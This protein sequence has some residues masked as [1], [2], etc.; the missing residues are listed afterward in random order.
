MSNAPQR[1]QSTAADLQLCIGG[2]SSKGLK[3]EN[4]DAFAAIVPD[5]HELRAKGAVAA[6]ADG[7]SSANKAADASQLAVTQFIQEYLVTPETWSTQKSAAKVLTSLNNWLYSQGGFVEGLADENSPQWLTT[8]SALIAKSTTGYI[9]HVG[10]TRIT[11]YR[12]QQ[13][14][15]ITRDHNRKQIGQQA[16]L[17]RALGADNRLEVDVH[18]VDLQS[19]DLYMLS[20]D[21]IHDYITKATFQS[22][23]DSLPLS[24]K[25]SDLEA[26]SI[27]IVNTAL[28]QGSN[29]NVT[30]LLVYVQAVPNRKL[31]E[32]QRDLSAKSIP[33]ALKVGQKLDGY[34]VK[35]VIHASIRSHLY[36][37][38]DV[39]TD[40]PYVLKAPSANFADDAIYL[41]GFMREAWVGER[42]K[43]GN[44][45]RVL[46]GRKNSQFLYH[47][48]E[49]LQGQTLGEWLHDNPKPSIALVRDIMKQVISALRAFQRLDLVH[50]DL[51]PDNIM[52]DQYGHIKL[53]DYGT[54]FVASLDENQETIKEE[55]PFGS[56]NYIAPE[57]LLH[58]KA[59]NQSDLFSLGV[60][61]YEMLSGELPYKPMQRAEVTIKDYNSMQYR[62]IKQFRP[63]LPLWLDLSLQ[64]AT[65]A[66]PRLRYKA[67]SEFFADL[68]NPKTNA[69]EE[70]KSQPLLKRNPILF[71]QSLS[72]L[73][74]VGLIAALL[75]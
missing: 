42:I 11:K 6:I 50:R 58:M 2:F 1:G 21:G 27:Q 13:L 57:T 29:D 18:K 67:F 45:M 14:E 68:S 69:V 10:D 22:L 41:Q 56:L 25:K 30:C 51:K 39:E 23:F 28:E 36:L 52:I 34:L 54:V 48:C 64:K 55:V 5:S 4:E 12:N 35:K 60:I 24:P 38:I 66:D 33:P 49:Y 7:L 46:P 61:C 70:Y 37:V 53:I 32:I 15:V 26:L 20:C 44:V 63:E 74:F 8:F 31:A 9:F 73:L 71:W 65:E 72:A 3:A 16:L 43:H 17:T 59:D 40:K 75:H 47:V 19:G 62:S